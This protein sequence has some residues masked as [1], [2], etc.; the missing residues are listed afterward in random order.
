[1][2]WEGAPP[3]VA[4]LGPALRAQ[5]GTRALAIDA[6]FTDYRYWG[7]NYSSFDRINIMTYD[8]TGTWDPYT[9]FDAALYGPSDQAVWSI[10]LAVQRFLAN[11]TPAS[12][13]TIGIPFYGYQWSGGGISGPRQ[14]WSSTPSLSQINYNV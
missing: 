6:G 5:L 1:I 7:G 3:N 8:M 14:T 2:D 13:I 10:D 9:W 11:G 12:R 4:Q